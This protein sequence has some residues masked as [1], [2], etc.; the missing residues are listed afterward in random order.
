MGRFRLE[1]L[2]GVVVG[3]V[4][5][6]VIAACSNGNAESSLDVADGVAPTS[7]S[8]DARGTPVTSASEDGSEA[9]P[10]VPPTTATPVPP[11]A[12]PTP[13]ATPEPTATPTPTPTP[14]PTATPTPRP[15]LELRPNTQNSLSFKDAPGGGVAGWLYASSRVSTTAEAPREVDG[16]T[17][18]EVVTLDGRTGWMP[19]GELV[20]W[21]SG[22]AARHVRGTLGS[23]LNNRYVRPSDPPA[24][25]GWAEA[26][27]DQYVAAVNRQDYATAYASRSPGL[28]STMSLQGFSNSMSSTRMSSVVVGQI[29]NVSYGNQ[30][31]SFSATVAFVSTQAANLGPS[32]QTCS[33][34]ILTYDLSSTW[35]PTPL[36]F[37]ARVLD[38]SPF[39]CSSL[40]I[41]EPSL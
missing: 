24:A 32:G 15:V 3:I 13:T 38:G 11:T 9:E 23:V 41:P 36:I 39:A 21:Q 8:A 19:E 26:T 18:L 29:S 34:W 27:F 35:Q 28:N 5:A 12:T 20:P 37:G 1:K 4:V 25:V 17:W 22:D 10:T 14:E 2:V 40:S 30:Q 7:A 6:L 31:T 33:V 16:Q